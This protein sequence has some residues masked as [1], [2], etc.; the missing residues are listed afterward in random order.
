MKSKILLFL[1]GILLV[2]GVVESIQIDEEVEERLNSSDEVL[3]IVKLKDDTVQ[4]PSTLSVQ[5]GPQKELRKQR[6]EAKKAMISKKQDKV[7]SKLDLAP[8]DDG[9]SISSSDVDLKLGHKYSTV[10]SFSGKLTRKGFEK[11]KNDPDVERIYLDRVAEISLD[12]SVAQINVDDAVWGVQV[13]GTN[14]TGLHETVCVIDTGID[15]DHTAF[16]G[17]ILDEYCFCSITDYNGSGGCCPNNETTDDSAEDDQ[18]HGTHC[19]GIAAGNHST[20]TG[21]ATDAGIISIKVCNSSGSCLFSSVNAG[22]DWC[23]NNATKYNISAISISIGGGD[24]SDYCNSFS[25]ADYIDTA[26][27]QNILVAVSAG[28]DGDTN[29]IDGPACVENAT[30]VGAVDNSDNVYLNYNRADILNLLAPGRFI[31]APY[32]DGLTT[33][34]SGTSMSTPHVAGAALL[35]NQFMSLQGSSA[36]PQEIEDTLNVT[37]VRKYDSEGDRYLSRIDVYAAIQSFDEIPPNVTFVAPGNNTITPNVSV[38]IN[39][40][41]YDYLNNISSCLLEWNN[42][43]ESMTKVGSDNDVYCYKNKSIVGHGIFYYKVYAND[44]ENNFGVSELRQINITDTAPNIT[45]FYPAETNFSIAEPDN[46]TFNIT[47]TDINNDTI[48]VV[49]YRNGTLVSSL[50]NYTFYGNYSAAGFYNITVIIS[51]G[52]LTDSQS[53][54][55]TVNESN[56]APTAE[57]VTIAST[58]NLNRTNGTLMGSWDFLDTDGHTQQDNETKWYNNSV[59]IASLANLT[60]LSPTNTSKHQNWTFGVRVYDGYDWSAWVNSTN[61][62]IQNAAPEFNESLTQQSAVSGQLFTYDVNCSDIDNDAVTYYINNTMLSINETNGTINDTPTLQEIGTYTIQVTCGD[63]EINTSQTFDYIITDATN[64]TFSSPVNYSVD[65]KRYS[66]FTANIT[67]NDNG[68]SHYIFSTNVTGWQNDTAVSMSGLTVYNATVSKN[69]TIAQGN[70]VCW[71][72]WA[73]DT[74]GN[75]NTSNQYCFTI[76]NT[77]PEA[78]NATITSTDNLNRTNGT[79]AGSWDIYDIDNDQQT[80]NQTKWYNNSVEIA[81]LR[82]LTSINFENTTKYENWTFSVRVYDGNDWSAW[83]NSTNLTIQNSAPSTPA[84]NLT[85]DEPEL[86][87]DLWCNITTQST[88]EDQ[89]T[90]Q[91]YYEWYKDGAL[92]RTTLT[93]QIYNVLGS[94]NTSSGEKWNCTVIPFDGEVNGT[95]ASDNVSL[96]TPPQA[97][98][99]VIT[100]TDNL[101]RTNGTLQGTWSFYDADGHTQQDNETKWYNNSVEI[102]SLANLT[103][104]SPTNTSKNQNWTFSVRVYDGNTWSAWA[105]STILIIQNDIPPTPAI[106]L[107][108]DEPELTDD[109]WCNITTQST[110]E[111]QDTIQYYYEWY[112]GGSLNRTILTTQIYY[113][114]GSGNTSNGEEW[115]CTVIPYDGEANGTAAS[116]KVAI[117]NEPPEAQDVTLTS[118]DNLNR[119]NGTLQG[120]WSF[121]DADGD[122]QQ[123]NQT[124]WYNNSDEVASL[125]GLATVASSY[126]RRNQNW[127]FSVRVYDSHD[128]SNWT[129]SSTMA[130]QNQ[131]PVLESISDITVNETQL[132]NITASATDEDTLTYDINDTRFTKTNNHFTW[133]TELTDSGVYVVAI[134][135]TDTISSASQNVTVTVLDASD[136]DGDGDPDF[137]DTDDDNDNVPDESDYLAGNVTN[138]NSTITVKLRVN[139]SENTSQVFNTTLLVNV[140]DNND[141]TLVEFNWDFSSRTLT[142]DWIVDYNSTGGTIR[143][144]DLDLTS[145]GITKTVYI[146]QSDSTYNYVCIAD[147]ETTPVSSLGAS[148]SGYTRVSCGSSGQCIDLGDIFKVST[149]SH[150]AVRG[151]YYDDSGDDDDDDSNGGTGGGGHIYGGAPFIGSSVKKT[152]VRMDLVPNEVYRIEADLENLALTHNYFSVTRAIPQVRVTME[153]VGENNIELPI[154]NAYQYFKITAQGMTPADLNSAEIEFRVS[155]AW[156]KAKN[157]DE[158]MVSLNI[159]DGAWSKLPTYRAGSIDGELYFVSNTNKFGYFAITSDPAIIPEEPVVEI[160]ETGVG[161]S[162]DITPPEEERAT[163]KEWPFVRWLARYKLIIILSFVVVAIAAASVF[164]TIERARHP[165]PKLA[166]YVKHSMDI[167]KNKARI[168]KELLDSG[169]P[170]NLVEEELRK[171]KK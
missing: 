76:A 171:Y 51:D 149:L 161:I 81:S 108:P 130:I 125:A 38:I 165:Y 151:I 98:N 72:Y 100:S 113:V 70:V 18:G 5:S 92:N 56:Q 50:D 95:A 115:N 1:L 87:D 75:E 29:A 15:T 141:N 57:N 147:D 169:W 10:N 37:G 93:T 46:Q 114:L 166:K 58:D 101:N 13:N 133:Q 107:T 53:W 12:T 168:K 153:T 34:M 65:F 80:D 71:Y 26:V 45:G 126:T 3:V 128:W 35:I 85:P 19:A 49:W 67:I 154:R 44:T 164:Y 78:H 162:L 84:I 64:P 62:T 137:N 103:L 158:S 22:I 146:N 55:F 82:N 8:E 83:V 109:L 131:P 54:N 144:K 118:T 48:T 30:P 16:S 148:C 132:V 135:V 39:V 116:D 68:L 97:Q 20:Y 17:R 121:Y 28:N 6:L 79:L 2:A 21:V 105:N 90:I 155:D 170:L 31:T 167:G 138:I 140:T 160:N 91:Y 139:G 124:K 143:I 60:S 59:E 63:G 122:T 119:T 42:T 102:A 23:T 123:N 61:L 52:T 163:W 134:N 7:L 47:Y 159:Y 41:V 117:G 36:T 32:N 11:L 157:F 156:L 136:F 150:S 33:S 112:K 129:N 24:Y 106:N 14:I 74:S 96:N 127:T 99:V 110:D 25:S 40:T 77:A 27:A 111:D 152:V 142:V 94:D 69:I 86:T 120:T 145:A 9:L 4:E 104:L 88:D 43:N 66:N 73:N 89:D